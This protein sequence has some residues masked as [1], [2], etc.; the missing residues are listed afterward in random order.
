MMRRPAALLGAAGLV[1][2]ATACSTDP[3]ESTATSAASTSTT[4]APTTA[5]PTS[6]PTSTTTTAIPATTSTTTSTTTTTTT[7]TTTSTSTPSTTTTTTLP[8][9]ALPAGIEPIDAL[10]FPTDVEV[11]IG[12]SV[13]GRPITVIRRGDPSGTRVL[14]VGAIHGNEADG[15]SIIDRL[16]VEPVPDGVELWLV[17][18]M[19]PDGQARSDRQNAN[20]VD[21]NRNF[22]ENWD[23]L[24]EPGF[25]QYG[26]SAPA[27]EPETRAMVALGAS[28]Q[29]Q[30]I[31]WYHQDLFRIAPGSGRSGEI[32]TRYADV[33]GLPVVDITG[34]TYT[35]TASQWSRTVIPEAGVGITVEL[36]PT[37]SEEEIVAH[38]GA[39]YT[40]ATEFF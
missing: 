20:A 8:P 19:N 29:P 13:E 9:P 28:V 4:P 21:L 34:G 7:T 17:R 5:T 36:G 39:V 15:V 22:P 27:S 12:R 6:T 25:W 31:L 10:A 33:A 32:R 35:G 23:V 18:S 11:E 3:A 24:G 2:G 37:L 1:L 16:A 26:G 14:A 40:I 38:V 30:I